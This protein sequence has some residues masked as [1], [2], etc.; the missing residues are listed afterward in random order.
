MS[1]TDDE[2]ERDVKKLVC[3]LSGAE[4]DGP[5]DSA[6]WFC[7][8]THRSWCNEQ[9]LSY[10]NNERLEFLGDSVLQ[11][12]VTE[13][14]LD[15][16]P[17]HNEGQLSMIRHRLVNNETLST[18]G[19]ELGVP[20]LLRI[21]VGEEAQG[22][23]RRPKM[24]ANAVESLLAACYLQLG[25]SQTRTIVRRL[26]SSALI[27][28]GSGLTP[29][30]VFQEWAQQHHRCTPTYLTEERI[31]EPSIN[32]HL[33]PE[34][35]SLNQVFFATASVNGQTLGR[36]WGRSKKRAITAAATMAAIELNLWPV[37]PKKNL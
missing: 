31:P 18:V 3:R 36:G 30:Q 12:I 21:G 20:E 19:V 15:E 7:A 11:L 17:D 22:A 6:L 14:L 16:F 29:K 1:S 25:I 10:P 4:A 35:R 13:W 34:L 9:K 2:F 5:I 26:F 32:A 23:R 33:P 28:H 37:S 8:L 27:Q 24:I